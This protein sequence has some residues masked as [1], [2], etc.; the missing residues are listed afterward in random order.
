MQVSRLVHII[1]D[2]SPP[3]LEFALSQTKKLHGKKSVVQKKDIYKTEELNQQCSKT[4]QKVFE[5]R[6][7]GL[8]KLK[9]ETRNY[10]L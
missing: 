6:F 2:V 7:N 4:S 10:E 5:I 9:V 1:G 8:T 3:L